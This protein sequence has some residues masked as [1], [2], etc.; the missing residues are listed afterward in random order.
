MA[1]DQEIL[2]DYPLTRDF[3]DFNRLN[4]QH[5]L[6]RKLFGYNIHPKI[7]RNGGKLKIADVGV[8]TGAW[9]LDILPDLDPSAELVG[10]DTD[11][12]QVGPKEWLPSNL[13]LREWDVSGEVPQDL[14]GQFD[15][16]NLRLF[17]FIIRDDPYPILRNLIKMLKPGGYVQWSEADID[18]WHIRT[19]SPDVPTDHMA[20]LWQKSVPKGS[21]LTPTWVSSLPQAFEKEGLLDVEADWQSGDPL[22][23][24]AIHWCN[25]PVYEMVSN[26]MRPTHPELAAEI[27]E[28]IP[29]A[30]IQSRKGAM[31]AFNR[32][33]VVG[34]KA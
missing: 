22:T 31:F 9:L 17:G 4:L 34:R 16:V 1:E 24:L 30:I 5:Q 15:I 28:L 8:G 29:K 33:N 10:I 12:S 27:D 18:S 3:I 14:V 7:P 2:K 32:V 11:I 25:L 26:Q 21:R 20:A 23:T 13:S 6:W 19:T